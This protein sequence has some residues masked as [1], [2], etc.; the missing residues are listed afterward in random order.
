M[1]YALL[2]LPR[3]T[4]CI[5]TKYFNK[6]LIPSTNHPRDAYMNHR[7]HIYSN[8][9]THH[10]DQNVFRQTTNRTHQ[11]TSCSPTANANLLMR[12]TETFY[13]H[14]FKII[15]RVDRERHASAHHKQTQTVFARMTVIPI[16]ASLQTSDER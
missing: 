3:L 6:R 13:T 14:P 7:S 1:L 16:C 11:T 2:D 5:I 8:T 9:N 10:I 15:N 12:I 4:H